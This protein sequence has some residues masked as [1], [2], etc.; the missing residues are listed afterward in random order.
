[1][2]YWKKAPFGISADLRSSWP[3]EQDVIDPWAG[4][5]LSFS[6]DNEAYIQALY[7]PHKREDYLH[8]AEKQGLK[9][10]PY[11]DRSIV[12]QSESILKDKELAAISE[13]WVPDI[14][15]FAEERVLGPF[16]PNHKLRTLCG[17]VLCFSSL[18]RHNFTP[19]G[20]YG[21]LK[22]R[23][24]GTIDLGIQ[25][26]TPAMI[27]NIN[28][29]QTVTPLLPIEERYIPTTVLSTLPNTPF[30][31]ARIVHTKQGYKLC[32]VLPLPQASSKYI[33]HR[34]QLE[35][36]RLQYHNR[37]IYWEDMLRFRSELLYRC[38]LEYCFIVCKK[39]TEQCLDYF[40]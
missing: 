9:T 16:A 4:D 3:I 29:N 23:K 14:G 37:Y 26:K 20:Q 12:H 34:I 15:I 18:L 17:A 1:M 5:E 28:P 13:D 27:W 24:K 2:S 31:V 11:H 38:S 40:F 35:W 19:A 6:Q 39:E 7:C 33:F 25:A 30:M 21:S 10:L 22:S 8:Q 32:S 36:I